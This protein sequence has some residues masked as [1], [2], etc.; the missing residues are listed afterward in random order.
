[1]VFWPFSLF[2]LCVFFVPVVAHASEYRWGTSQLGFTYSSP[3]S[4]CLALAKQMGYNNPAVTGTSVS[5]D[6][7]SC[8][9][10]FERSQDAGGGTGQIYGLSVT[11]VGDSCASGG[12]YDPST[13]VCSVPDDKCALLK[14]TQ[15]PSFRFQSTTDG[16]SGVISK[17]GCAVQ[18]GTGICVTRTAPF[19]DCTFSGTVTGDKMDDKNGQSTSDCSGAS[20]TDGQP[21]KEVKEDPCNAIPAGSGFT[22]ISSKS[23]DNPG[24]SQCGTANGAY[25]CVDNPKPSSSASITKTEQTTTSNSDGSTTT[26]TTNTTTTTVCKGIGNC[27]TGTTV[28]VTTGGTNAN[29]TGKPNST[30]CTGPEC[31]GGKLTPGNG[32]GTGNSGTGEGEEGDDEQDSVS[33]DMQCE[34]VVACSGDVIQCAVLRQEQQSRCA[35]KDFRDLSD[36]KTN[37]QL[38]P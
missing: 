28:T 12:T 27:T 14:G 38:I 13:G 17:N 30:T 32:S 37:P 23:E 26:K 19:Y 36:S 7:A 3:S 16:P 20:C 21:Q 5:G 9:A 24:K 11:R 29:G 8:S 25:V 18:L 2:F 1:M 6:Q 33:G 15:I 34:T 10:T 31:G 4:A 35:D 22:C